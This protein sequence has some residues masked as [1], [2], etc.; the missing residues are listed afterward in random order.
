MK[1]LFLKE[2]LFIYLE[3]FVGV[4]FAT[5]QVYREDGHRQEKHPFEDTSF[6]SGSK[7]DGGTTTYLY[8][9]FD[10]H[11]GIEAAQFAV[12]GL[13]AELLLGQLS[14]K[15]RDQDIKEALRSTNYC[16]I[17]VLKL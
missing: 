16:Y 1:I 14:G 13:A 5:N 3:L 10:G 9:V 11:Y 2:S 4:G 8:G 12:Q 6:H 15:I 7:E 17:D